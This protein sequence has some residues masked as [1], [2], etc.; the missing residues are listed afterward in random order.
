MQ[1]ASRSEKRRMAA[2][3]GETGKAA[4]RLRTGGFGPI[5]RFRWFAG[6]MHAA[7]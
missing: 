6:S 2:W 5:G 4:G 3:M 1:G 7:E